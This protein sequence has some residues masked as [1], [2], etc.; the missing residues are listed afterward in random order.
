MKYIAKIKQV[1]HSDI[2][3]VGITENDKT[4]DV[5]PMSQADRVEIVLD[6]SETE[7]CRMYRYNNDE[8]FCGDTWHETFADALG[9]ATFEY[10]LKR[11]DFELIMDYDITGF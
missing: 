7:P 5:I 4:K 8:E 9:Q 11:E 3:K 2:H 10:G 1:L 6:G